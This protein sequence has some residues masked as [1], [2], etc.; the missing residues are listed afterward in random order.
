MAKAA[1]VYGQVVRIKRGARLLPKDKHT[2][3]SWKRR[4]DARQAI[5]ASYAA[6]NNMPSGDINANQ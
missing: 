2:K 6:G 1:K 4:N 5:Q 3:E